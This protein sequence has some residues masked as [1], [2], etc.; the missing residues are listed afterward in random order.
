MD[1]ND[2]PDLFTFLMENGYTINTQLTQMM[3][4]SNV[5]MDKEIIC[6]IHIMVEPIGIILEVC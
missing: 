2:I 6:F 1:P 4:T 3:Q 5:K